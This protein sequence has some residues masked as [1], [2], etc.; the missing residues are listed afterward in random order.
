MVSRKN[1]ILYNF[2]TR[3]RQ[4]LNFYIVLFRAEV[5]CNII[6]RRVA[7]AIHRS[8]IEGSTLKIPTNGETLI[9]FGVELS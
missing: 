1:Y 4:N 8:S 5:A 7:N 6:S 2:E 3:E 9:F